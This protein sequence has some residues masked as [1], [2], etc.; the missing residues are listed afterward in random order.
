MITKEIAFSL[1]VNGKAMDEETLPAHWRLIDYL[2]EKC[3]L[4]GTKFGC[5]GGMCK[6]CTVAVIDTAGV[7]HAVPACSTS[8]ETCN[9]WNIVTVEGLADYYGF[10]ASNS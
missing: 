10:I 3:A 1:T 8:L 2:H 4:T 5:G 6:A 9:N 7:Y